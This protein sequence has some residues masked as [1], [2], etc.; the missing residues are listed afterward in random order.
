MW[1][2][3][4]V[5]MNCGIGCVLF[6]SLV[7]S[8]KLY[9]MKFYICLKITVLDYRWR[10]IMIVVE[11]TYGLGELKLITCACHWIWLY[12]YTLYMYGYLGVERGCTLLFKLWLN[13]LHM[14]V[15]LLGRREGMDSI[16]IKL[17]EVSWVKV[18]KLYMG[19]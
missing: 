18:L 12:L 3:N 4:G 5:D 6:H 1:N 2:W 11:I 14:Y 15:W 19:A 10:I 9:V 16:I 17:A 13:A 8:N 7:V